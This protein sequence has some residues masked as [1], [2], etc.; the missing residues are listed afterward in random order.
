[1]SDTPETEAQPN[2]LAVAWERFTNIPA[3]HGILLGLFALV[4]ALLLAL[5]DEATRGAIADRAAEDL[6]ASLGQVI[7][8]SLHDN[9]LV[10]STF[11]ITDEEAGELTVYQAVQA[12]AVTAVAYEMV[13]YGY[14]GA[15][16]VLM[17]VDP[18]GEILGVRVLAHAETPGLGDKIETA[19]DDWIL[20]FD[21]RSLEDP[22]PAKWKVQKDGGVFDQFSGATIT[23]R[24]VVGAIRGGLELFERHEAEL[25]RPIEE[26]A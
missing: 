4:T 8:E 21:G 13:G 2:A 11:V 22:A 20:G 14:A 9:D 3:G 17:A 26:N 18:A 6:A 15:I 10:A 25:M 5:A 16:R 19:K 1:M 7:S 23:P 24:A 12:G